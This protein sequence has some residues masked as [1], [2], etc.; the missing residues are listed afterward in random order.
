MM[1]RMSSGLPWSIC[2]PVMNKTN[3]KCTSVNPHNYEKDVQCLLECWVS[4]CTSKAGGFLMFSSITFSFCVWSE[5][6]WWV[7]VIRVLRCA[8][9][10]LLFIR[11]QSRLRWISAEWC[12]GCLTVSLEGFCLARVCLHQTDCWEDDSLLLQE[13]L[14]VLQ[15][16]WREISWVKQT[17]CVSCIGTPSIV[18]STYSTR[19]KISP[20]FLFRGNLLWFDKTL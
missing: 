3:I 7:K 9:G 10:Y 4:S 6:I 18:F 16:T 8:V 2:F 20:W 17:V 13:T 15:E 11:Y 1:K 19:E 5:R 12:N 14:S